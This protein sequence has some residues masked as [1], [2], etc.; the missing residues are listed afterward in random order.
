MV[1][2]E[3]S[4]I[5]PNYNHA[6]FLEQRLETIFNQTYQNFEVILLDDASTDSSTDILQSY[7]SNKKVSHFIVNE[8]NSGSPFKQW[9]KGIELATGEYIWIA[10]SDDFCTPDF[11]EHIFSFT[12]KGEQDPGIVYSQSIDV[13]EHGAAISSRRKYTS[14]FDPNIWSGDF[15]IDGK[16]FVRKYLKVKNVIPNASAVIFKRSL[17]DASMLTSE[18]LNMNFCGDWLFWI[19]L[20]SKTEV[21]FLAKESNFFREHSDTSRNHREI[22]RRLTRLHEEKIIRDYLDRNFR[23][24]QHKE[25]RALYKNWFRIHKLRAL[26]NSNFYKI[27]LR[28]TNYIRFLF[29][30][31]QESWK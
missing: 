6:Q 14:N 8:E 30:R 2:P 25:I 27:K 26:L 15:L 18:L 12:K 7:A 16:D 13:D 1:K 9:K 19:R 4:I 29:Y 20:C 31:L 17:V 11:L 23:L 21:G 28:R 22:H 10:E 24:D 5:I 3:I